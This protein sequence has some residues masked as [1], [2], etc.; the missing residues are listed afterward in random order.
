MIESIDAPTISEYFWSLSLKEMDFMLNKVETFEEL[1][2]PSLIVSIMGYVI[3][4]PT[5]WNILVYSPETS[6]LD[7]VE[8]FRLARV[9]FDV[10]VYNHKTDKVVTSHD[11]KV[12]VLDYFPMSKLRTPSL[13]KNTMLCHAIGPSHWICVA[14]TDNYNKYLKDKVIGDFYF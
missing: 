11:N 9:S 6:Q 7:T 8:L 5:N 2:T 13:H 3:E 10:M 12:Q 4:L 14:P 1:S